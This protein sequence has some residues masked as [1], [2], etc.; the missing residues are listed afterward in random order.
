MKVNHIKVE[1]SWL[2]LCTGV[3]RFLNLVVN[4]FVQQ[5]QLHHLLNLIR[6]TAVMLATF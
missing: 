5:L 6:I 1:A 2:L 4:I 3:V